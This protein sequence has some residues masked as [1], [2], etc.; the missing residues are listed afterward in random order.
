MTTYSATVYVPG[1]APRPLLAAELRHLVWG[2]CD[3]LLTCDGEATET[4]LGTTWQVGTD[5]LH[6]TS[7]AA[8]WGVCNAAGIGAAG[9]PAASR[10]A[11]RIHPA[12]SCLVGP[13]LIVVRH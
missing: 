10:A 5:V 7:T 1:H 8:V 9:N 2:V 13:V 11:R 4:L 3:G 6:V 12:L